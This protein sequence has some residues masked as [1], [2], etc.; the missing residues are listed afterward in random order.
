MLDSKK[1]LW[2][3]PD[4]SCINL[5][6]GDTV[7]DVVY[8]IASKLCTI[9]EDLDLSTVDYSC[10]I[11]KSRTYGDVDLFLLF[12]ILLKN[13][14][15][16]KTLLEEKIALND[17]SELLVDSLNLK[18]FLQPYLDSICTVVRFYN[19]PGLEVNPNHPDTVFQSA[20]IETFNYY[21]VSDI[22]QSV[23]VWDTVQYIKSDVNLNEIC[24]CE[25]E[26][27]N[28][29][30]KGVLQ[31]IVNNFCQTQ[32]TGIIKA[33]SEFKIIPFNTI[34]PN[35]N[36]T[37]FNGISE[38]QHSYYISSVTKKIWRWV[39][40]ESSYI[41][42]VLTSANIDLSSLSSCLLQSEI[43][44]QNWISLY[45][46]YEEPTITS[47]LSSNN[48]LSNHVINVT[49]TEICNIK[50]NLG[51]A[52]DIYYSHIS[53]CSKV[54]NFT[55]EV[56]SPSMVILGLPVNSL[57]H[58]YINKDYDYPFIWNGLQYVP[59]KVPI[60]YTESNQWDKICNIISR[61]KTLETTCCTPTCDNTTIGFSTTYNTED[62]I[63]TLVFDSASGTNIGS[64]FVDCGSILTATD[65][66]GTKV[67][68]NIELS[69]DAIIELD[70]SALDLSKNVTVN[71]KSCLSNDTLTCKTCYSQNLPIIETC[72]LCK[73]CAI[74]NSE[75]G[76]EKIII[77]YTV[78]SKPEVIQTSTLYGGQCLTFILP[79]DEPTIK[80]V[81]SDS[82][83]IVLENDPE[84]P[85]NDVEIPARVGDSC[86]FFP[87]P[88]TSS[89]AKINI[90][91][92]LIGSS[93]NMLPDFEL[94]STDGE[95]H[96]FEYQKLFTYVKP[97]GINLTGV[98]DG[99]PN[100]L[101]NIPGTNTGD[102]VNWQN[103]LPT[104]ISIADDSIVSYSLCT[105][106]GFT[107][108]WITFG[109]YPIPNSLNSNGNGAFSAVGIAG[110]VD[111]NINYNR[112]KV[113]T[114]K[115][116]IIIKLNNQPT[117]DNIQKPE[118]SLKDPISGN[119]V[120]IK[121]ELLSDECECPT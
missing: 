105:D 102:T 31:V 93:F 113:G 94:Q 24:V 73:I 74:D 75:S 55:G 22:D 69:Q 118:L 60:I 27:I 66:K 39:V 29:D 63:F 115:T 1:I 32:S 109:T 100:M 67:S 62:N 10:I 92:G 58:F 54:I 41:P 77:Y 111:K 23:W 47:C 64:D 61:L 70:A 26:D 36:T 85:C 82:N 33:C 51:S 12:S 14:C 20:E 17:T 121:G 45:Q 56:N 83:L 43:A 53:P 95:M 114:S 44:L 76:K 86:W 65:S 81:V 57:N 46:V 30:V 8:G 78:A 72:G 98:I 84:Y 35:T 91:R 119:I 107:G 4:I 48:I 7:T 38:N 9:L 16:L 89:P 21:Y 5:C 50:N 52:R 18:C 49:D 106:N 116:G 120:Y 103:I 79:E 2:K 97:L 40:S 11:D 42:S 110:S 25:L 108:D 68:M 34:D 28:L 37:V 112:T 117:L 6:T 59:F 99:T 15:D 80:S 101:F 96:S 90:D 13:D 71:I 88:T 104:N 19:Q 3:G 87:L